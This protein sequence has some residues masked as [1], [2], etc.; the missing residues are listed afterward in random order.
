V[1]EAVAAER[2]QSPDAIEI[3]T[4]G[5][6]DGVKQASASLQAID[7]GR[8]EV[9]V[10]S[11]FQKG[12]LDSSGVAAI[13][14][15]VGL[16]FV[17]IGRDASRESFPGW[18]GFA[19]G[20]TSGEQRITLDGPRTRVA[21]V[22]AQPARMPAILARPEEEGAVASMQRAVSAAGAPALPADRGLTVIFPGAPVP[23]IDTVRAPWMIEALLRARAD[24]GLRAAA[25]AHAADLDPQLSAAWRPIVR[26][27]SGNPLVA[28]AAAQQNLA[29]YVSASPATLVAAAAL[30]SLLYAVAP[31]QPWSEREVESI[32]PSQL[33]AWTR[34]AGPRPG[35]RSG[36]APGDAQWIWGLALLMLAIETV[37]RRARPESR[38]EGRRAA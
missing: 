36:K 22:A 14:E 33:S 3:R 34:Q 1:A 38:E 26:T 21:L 12:S 31:P 4:P 32:S 27:V 23:A 24:E 2:Q 25:S 29:A 35:Q 17:R 20:G 6:A 28:V 16:R 18:R 19:A 37:V 7:G 9:V 13:P 8:A 30:R 5:L 11:D 15:G 10:I